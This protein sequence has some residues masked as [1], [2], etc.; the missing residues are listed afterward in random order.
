MSK[1]E[2]DCEYKSR[3][4]EPEDQGHG[5]CIVFHGTLYVRRSQ[6]YPTRALL[7]LLVSCLPVAHTKDGFVIVTNQTVIYS[8]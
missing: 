3:Y 7:V 1:G 2:Q 5:S 8:H 6:I 4:G